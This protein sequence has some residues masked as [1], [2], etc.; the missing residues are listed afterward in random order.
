MWYPI[1]K[2]QYFTAQEEM[3]RWTLRSLRCPNFSTNSQDE[4][5]DRI[6]KT[7]SATKP[8]VTSRCKFCNQE[9]P[10]FYTLRP[11]KN[12]QPGLF[13][14]SANV[15]P[16]DVITDFEVANPKV[17]SRSSQL[18]LE[19][20]ELEPAR[21]K[22]FNNAIE[23]LNAK[24]V[25]EKLPHFF[26]NLKSAEKVSLAVEL[27]ILKSIEDGGCR[28]FYAQKNPASLILTFVHQ[29][30]LGKARRCSQQNWRHRVF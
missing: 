24:I 8:V 9:F 3:L 26:S 20:S 22:I 21:R 14:K 10:A 16:H 5:S 28:W 30:R 11:N 25:E 15:D 6:A 23:N 4:L 13:I 17:E 1:Y 19:D 2:K 12:T 7:H 29:G 18:L 27:Y